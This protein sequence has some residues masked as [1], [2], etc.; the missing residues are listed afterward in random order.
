MIQNVSKQP[1]QPRFGSPFVSGEYKNERTI[2]RGNVKM[3]MQRS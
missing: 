2:Q 1:V 3:P